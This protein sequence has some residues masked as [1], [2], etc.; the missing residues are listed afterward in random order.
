VSEQ[1]GFALPGLPSFDRA[2]VIGVLNVT[3]DS[4]SDGGN[5][6]VAADAVRHGVELAADGADIVDVGGEST[7]P[8]AGRIDTDEELRRTLPV[9][10]ALAAEGIRV[11]IDTTR[12]VVAQ[13]ALGAGAVLVNDVSGG[14][15][16]AAMAPLIATSGVAY[17]VMHSRGTSAD[18]QQLAEY[19]DVVRDVRR[20]LKEQLHAISA[21][22]VRREQ[23]V[24]DPGIGFAKDADGNLRL[25]S[26]LPQ[27]REL[28]LPVLVGASRKSFLGTLLDGRGVDQRDDATQAITALAAWEGVWGVRVHAARAAADAVRV[29]AAI[30]SARA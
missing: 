8:G 16:D 27:I 17:V 4:F 19:D 18:M 23:L 6:L 22:G 1:S 14:R 10:K 7:R 13:A 9:V 5:W 30:R 21:A 15:A 25:L 29:V 26:A 12:S 24:I 11:S 3:P 20:E 28:G 2:L